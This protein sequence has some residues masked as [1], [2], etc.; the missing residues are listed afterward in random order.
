MRGEKTVLQLNSEMMR[1]KE[2]QDEEIKQDL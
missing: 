2:D 1:K